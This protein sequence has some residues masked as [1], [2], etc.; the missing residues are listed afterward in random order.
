MIDGN[1]KNDI[2]VYNNRNS[3]NNII[4]NKDGNSENGKKKSSKNSKN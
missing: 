1:Y 2:E 4:N 3:D